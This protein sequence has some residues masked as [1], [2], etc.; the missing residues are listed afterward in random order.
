MKFTNLND[1]KRGTKVTLLI[2]DA[3]P[4]KTLDGNLHCAGQTYKV[5]GVQN[6]SFLRLSRVSDNA[7]LI[8]APEQCSEPLPDESDLTTLHASI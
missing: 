8:I 3:R 4:I 6:G 7:K 1:I 2:P 5:L